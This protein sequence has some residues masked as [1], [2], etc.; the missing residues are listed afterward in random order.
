MVQGGPR[1]ISS[2][3][4]APNPLLIRV[5]TERRGWRC[6][7]QDRAQAL[8]DRPRWRR[9]EAPG[10]PSTILPRNPVLTRP[11]RRR[12]TRRG[13]L[14]LR[15]AQDM[16]CAGCAILYEQAFVGSKFALRK[17]PAPERRAETAPQHGPRPGRVPAPRAGP[18]AGHMSAAG[19]GQ[20]L[21]VSAP[22]RAGLRVSRAG[23]RS[24][25]PA[26]FAPGSS[27]AEAPAGEAPFSGDQ[28]APA[29]GG[30]SLPVA[31]SLLGSAQPC[32]RA[33]ASVRA[34]CALHGSAANT[35]WVHLDFERLK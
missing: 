12:C 26:G 23:G 7:R 22:P 31:G 29:Q 6:T 14:F 2:S 34:G 32:A 21:R 33:P 18:G 20:H 4:P 25:A 27:S 13:A 8:W 9:E 30:V 5:Q 3:I 17:G 10:G 15:G 1:R 35:C 28:A 16:L 19:A 24:V 11:A